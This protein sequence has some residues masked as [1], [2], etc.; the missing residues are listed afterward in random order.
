MKA[1]GIARDLEALEGIKVQ[2]EKD[3]G[4]GGSVKVGDLAQV[5]PRGKN[6]VVL[7]GEKDVSFFRILFSWWRG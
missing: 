1:G 2:L 7:I 5:L 6:V 4:K 3:G